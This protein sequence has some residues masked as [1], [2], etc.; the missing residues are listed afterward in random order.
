MYELAFACKDETSGLATG[1]CGRLNESW[2]G[3][4]ELGADPV[5]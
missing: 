5:P 4:G 3:F 2:M 1:V